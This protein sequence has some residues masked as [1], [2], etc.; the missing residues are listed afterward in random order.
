MLQK[1]LH[2]PSEKFNLP[3][4]V[5]ASQFLEKNYQFGLGRKKYSSMSY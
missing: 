4:A 3:K 2:E 5:P 1:N